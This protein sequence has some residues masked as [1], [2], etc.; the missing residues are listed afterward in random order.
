[1]RS[2][3]LAVLACSLTTS[4]GP[5]KKSAPPVA[6]PPAVAAT[7]Y[8]GVLPTVSDSEEYAALLTHANE[9]LKA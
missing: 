1:M 4:A 6:P 2:I 8:V 3:L 5:K 7:P 9:L